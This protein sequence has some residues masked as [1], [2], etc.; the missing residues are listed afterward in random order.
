MYFITRIDQA[1]AVVPE[2]FAGHSNGFTKQ[3]LVDRAVG[4]PHTDLSANWIAANG[5]VDAVVH[6]YEFSM[7]VLKGE[8]TIYMMGETIT[9]KEDHV[10]VVPIATSYQL[11][12]GAQG[13][14]WLQCSAPGAVERPRRKDTYFTG[15]DLRAG[16]GATVDL[17]DPRT[18]R[19]FRFDPSSMNLNNL[20]V[21][22]KV[23]DPTVSASM[24]TALL[25]YSGIGVR[26]L[27]DQRVHAKLHTMFIVDYQ[28][29][30]IAH[31]HDH[32]FEETYTFTQGE[33][34]GLIEGKEY[35][36]VPGDV[37]W[38]GV[39]SDHGFQNKTGELVRWIETQSPQPPIQ[40]SYRFTRDWEY[41]D[42]KLQSE[43]KH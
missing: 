27:V 11:Q 17:R 21:G 2:V 31:P 24:A 12:A 42:Q 39:G 33:T 16:S 32:P 4:S 7:Y 37:L 40:H 30:A 14:H 18:Q 15:E 25:A 19:A 5:S 41:L 28:P 10:V 34:V 43:H 36:F 3:E 35:T 13:A 38:C 23:S 22:S 1:K 20:A 26:M 29:T 8:V 6:S 9:L